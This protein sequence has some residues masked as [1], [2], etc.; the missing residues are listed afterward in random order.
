M[1]TKFS[2]FSRRYFF[3]LYFIFGFIF[4]PLYAVCLVNSTAS[5]DLSIEHGVESFVIALI[6]GLL[7]VLLC[8]FVCAKVFSDLFAYIKLK[9]DPCGKFNAVVSYIASA[10]YTWCCKSYYEQYNQCIASAE[11]ESE[12]RDRFEERK[13]IGLYRE[14]A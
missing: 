5:P 13:L 10:F 1:N 8:A 2:E 3:V 4:T 9:C 6:V 14:D 11:L 7:V 12:T